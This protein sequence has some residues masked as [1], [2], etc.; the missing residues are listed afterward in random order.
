MYEALCRYLSIYP[1][2]SFLPHLPTSP[3]LSKPTQKK[4]KKKPKNS[5]THPTR[6]APAVEPP[7][8]GPA[9]GRRPLALLDP[10]DDPVPLQAGEEVV[11][12]PP[13]ARARGPVGGLEAAAAVW[14]GGGGGRV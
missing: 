12:R 3:P 7:P 14:G 10:V 11:P 13:A 6:R 4:T 5:P 9:H 1:F 2:L 8:L